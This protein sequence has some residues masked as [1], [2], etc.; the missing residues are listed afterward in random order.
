M[1]SKR[2][3]T[4]DQRDP[5]ALVGTQVASLAPRRLG[6]RRP[7]GGIFPDPGCGFRST[8]EVGGGRCRRVSIA[9]VE[10][11][12]E[13]R[14]G[15]AASGRRSEEAT[16][17]PNEPRI[18]IRPTSHAG[19]G[20][21]L[22]LRSLIALRKGVLCD[23]QSDFASPQMHLAARNHGTLREKNFDCDKKPYCT[24]GR[25]PS[26]ALQ[27]V[28]SSRRANSTSFLTSSLSSKR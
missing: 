27:P 25:F 23:L 22:E 9:A 20:H 13:G 24:V 17:Y 4:E 19:S 28:V 26:R 1:G 7:W 11:R 2:I 12:P 14:C 15:A 8:R 5:T 3:A 21:L 6:N 16:L 18:S 10:H